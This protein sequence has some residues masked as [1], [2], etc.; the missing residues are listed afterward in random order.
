MKTN[1]YISELEKELSRLP[2]KQRDDILKE[3]ASYINESQASYED[4]TQ[5]FGTAC[6]LALSYLEDNPE[7]EVKKI[8][9]LPK[10]QKFFI[11]LSVFSIALVVLAF[12][13][14]KY[15]TQDAFD[16]SKYNAQNIQDKI[17][18]NWTNLENIKNIE[19]HQASA[20]MYW[21]KDNVSKYSCAKE[22]TLDKKNTLIVKQNTCYF[23]LPKKMFH[24][25]AFQA[26]ITL[27]E[28][29]YKTAIKIDQAEL[30]IEEN[31]KIYEYIFKNKYSK[32]K[33][34]TS[35]KGNI[36]ISIDAFQASVNKYEY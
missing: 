15:F 32:I 11:G 36:L 13:L 28:P 34:L 12:F 30:R 20:V 29:L 3:I 26:D 31:S 14:F 4:V 22:A 1:T 18:K 9:T 17:T 16:Y 7:A 5:R 35:V 19:V 25:S 23:I 8:G 6:D 27:V 33:S 10:I 2:K 24:I 21:S